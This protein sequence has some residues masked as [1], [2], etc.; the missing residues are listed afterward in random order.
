GWARVSQSGLRPFRRGCGRVNRA[1]PRTSEKRPIDARM[2]AGSMAGQAEEAGAKRLRLRKFDPYS[3]KSQLIVD[4][5]IFAASFAFAYLMRF[6]GDVPCDFTRQ[7][8]HWVPYLLA[9][10]L[11]VNW[12]LGSYR[13]IWRY[14]WLP[15]AMLFDR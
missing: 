9:A 8:L 10:R 4:G 2:R 12:R 13:F 1:S 3:R 7:F 15:D 14:V 6:E 5:V 11:I